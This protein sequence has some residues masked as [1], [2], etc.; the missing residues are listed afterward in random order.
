MVNLNPSPGHEVCKYCG[1]MGFMKSGDF[2]IDRNF[3]KCAWCSGIGQK[4]LE[5]KKVAS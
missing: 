5:D 2:G 1:G 4:Y 3:V